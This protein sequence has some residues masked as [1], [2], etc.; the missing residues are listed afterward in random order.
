MKS[1]QDKAKE[2]A[3]NAAIQFIK[4]QMIVGLGTG[5]T[6]FYFIR[7][8]IKKCQEGLSIKVVV[9][10]EKSLKQAI[11]GHLLF[12]DLTQI[13]HVDIT[14]DGA[15]EIDPHNNMIK[16]G[17]GA[18]LREKIVATMSKEMIVIV[19]QG[20]LVPQLGKFHLPVE[21]ATFA[22]TATIAHL[23]AYGFNG[24]LRKNN[25]N[26][27]F[28]TDNGNYIYD[29]KFE[30]LLNDPKGVDNKIKSIPGVLETGFFFNIA[31]R[32]IVGKPDGSVEIRKARIQ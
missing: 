19:D 4:P 1:F 30:H 9:T 11:D 28:I 25:D 3:G 26:A 16:G 13:N 27:V 8:L 6:V 29:I 24:E 21:I 23:N 10:S 18:L 15:D 7:S 5:S 20:K 12:A 32:V 31:S 2:A 22:Y 14:V 17:G